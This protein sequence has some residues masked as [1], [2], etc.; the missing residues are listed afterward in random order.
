MNACG[1]SI[2]EQC[3]GLFD[4]R[5]RG[6]GDPLGQ[7]LHFLLDH[8]AVLTAVDHQRVGGD[9]RPAQNASSL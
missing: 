2:G 3:P 8:D 4:E 5:Q 7:K 6:T 9:S 1:C